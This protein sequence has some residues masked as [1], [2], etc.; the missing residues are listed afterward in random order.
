MADF[1]IHTYEDSYYLND[2]VS[3][4]L[5]AQEQLLNIFNHQCVAKRCKWF[6]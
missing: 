6:S 3:V 4:S 2:H 5:S 1:K